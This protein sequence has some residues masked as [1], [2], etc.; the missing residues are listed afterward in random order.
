MLEVMDDEHLDRNAREIGAHFMDRLLDMKDRF[1]I[2]GDVRGL[3]LMIGIELVLDRDTREPAD[4][5]TGLAW[6]HAVEVERLLIGKTGPVFGDY[7][8]VLK[9]K[10]A[11][12][13][14]RAEA[15]EMLDRFERVI[16][17]TQSQLDAH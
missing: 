3:G 15:D 17:F 16:A 4:E 9:L 12:N 13:T 14:T 8:N 7:G 2:I 5:L 10:P 11:V 1:P 6:K